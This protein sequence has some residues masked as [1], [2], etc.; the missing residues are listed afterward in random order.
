MCVEPEDPQKP[1]EAREVTVDD[2]LQVRH[3]ATAPLL[4]LLTREQ[5][6]AHEDFD[7]SD[8]LTVLKDRFHRTRNPG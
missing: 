7:R 1:P 5:T 6:H 4:E 2:P 8:H 3:T